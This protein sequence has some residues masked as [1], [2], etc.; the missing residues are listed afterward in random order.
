[1]V[2]LFSEGVD[3]PHP[4]LPLAAL[5]LRVLRGYNVPERGSLYSSNKN[6]F[7]KLTDPSTQNRNRL[8]TISFRRRANGH[9]DCSCLSGR[10]Q[11]SRRS[12]VTIKVRPLFP[13]WILSDNQLKLVL[14]FTNISCYSVSENNNL[15]HRSRAFSNSS[16]QE[17]L[18]SIK[19]KPSFMDLVS[20]FV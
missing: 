11:P 5:T 20:L 13:F 16:P 14:E 9:A 1:M 19:A 12:F 4:A 18:V 3:E 8:C 6:C 10:G 2:P 7:G 17:V 15:K